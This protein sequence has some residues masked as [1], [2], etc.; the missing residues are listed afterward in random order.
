VSE[1][2]ESPGWKDDE[3]ALLRAAVVAGV[4]PPVELLTGPM[5]AAEFEPWF[6]AAEPDGVSLS[7]ELSAAVAVASPAAKRAAAVAEATRIAALLGGAGAPGLA[8]ALAAAA[9]VRPAPVPIESPL[10]REVRAWLRFGERASESLNGP[11]RHRMTDAER[12]RGY[13]F[14]WFTVALRG[15]LH[16]DPDA[17]VRAALYPL[18]SGPAPLT[19]R[20]ALASVLRQ[21]EAGG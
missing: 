9:G 1:G 7:A 18:S 20:A 13:L 19:D 11:G 2:P 17:G 10:G 12:H 8:D 5:P 15:A 16:H 4:R 21:L 3:R 6:T 14:G